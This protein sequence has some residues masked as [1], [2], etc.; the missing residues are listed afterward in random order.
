MRSS[1]SAVSCLCTLVRATLANMQAPLF[2]TSRCLRSC[3]G[4]LGK[5]FVSDRDYA[6]A[7]HYRRRSEYTRRSP[8]FAKIG[9][10]HSMTDDSY[11]SRIYGQ[12]VQAP[13]Q[14]MRR[15]F[16]LS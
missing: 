7:A 6:S 15:R 2:E 1:F 10:V 13:T 4:W 11:R 3:S 16:P 8:R 5:P 14:A 12:H 9:K